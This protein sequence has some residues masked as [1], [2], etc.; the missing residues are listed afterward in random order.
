V[1]EFDKG[2]INVS[3]EDIGEM[4][5]ADLMNKVGDACHGNSVGTVHFTLSYMIAESIG[6]CTDPKEVAVGVLSIQQYIYNVA[7]SVYRHNK[8]KREAH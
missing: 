8:Q 7:M 6:D 2:I 1:K 4:V 5:C 3:M